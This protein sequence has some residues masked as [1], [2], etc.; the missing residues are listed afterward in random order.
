LRKSN[1]FVSTLLDVYPAIGLD[2][3][4][5]KFI[6]GKFSSPFSL[7][8]FRFVLFCDFLFYFF[9][10]MATGKTKQIKETF[11]S[12]LHEMKVS[13]LWSLKTGTLFPG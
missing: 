5:F 12:N 13:S 8:P 11:S 4:K 6:P 1:G 10:K 7:S 2:K 3:D 9:C